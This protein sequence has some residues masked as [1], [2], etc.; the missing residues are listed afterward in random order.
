[1][2]FLVRVGVQTLELVS[3]LVAVGAKE[4]IVTVLAHPTLFQNLSLAVET[5]VFFAFLDLGLE[6]D[7]QLMIGFMS[8]HETTEGG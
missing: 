6:D 4:K 1:V 3:F 8:T 5:L 2:I 7:L